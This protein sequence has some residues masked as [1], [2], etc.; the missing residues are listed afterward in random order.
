MATNNALNLKDQGV[1]YYNGTSTFTGIDGSTS[2]FVLT[3]T[4]TGAAPT[5]QAPATSGT[6][7]SVSGTTNRITSTGGNTPVIDISASYVGQSSITT[8][9]TIA[10]G[11][12]QGT[13][14][15]LPYGGTNANLT[16][17]NGGIFYSTASAGA[18]LAG[19]ATAGQI[20]RSGASTTPSWSTA[21]YPATAGTSGNVLTSDGT[22]WTSAA[23]SGASEILVAKVTLTS[24]QIKA[25]RATPI[26][27]IAAPGAGKVIMPV[28]VYYYYVYAGTNAFTNGQIIAPRTVNGATLTGL[29]EWGLPAASL[30]GT[31]SQTMFSGVNPTGAQTTS[32]DVI[33]K[34]VVMINLGAS[35][36]TGNAAND[37]TLEVAIVYYIWTL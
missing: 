28:N 34:A 15:G 12:W 25:I 27:I 33:N 22:N 36:I 10:S 4:G 17:S 16:A 19:T 35:E 32:T 18:I 24:A 14:V 9:G 21:T 29:F 26:Q 20:I 3:S 8:L 31:T 37:N 23:P 1:T 7:T 6:V 5:F 30:N 2:G 11:T 13:V